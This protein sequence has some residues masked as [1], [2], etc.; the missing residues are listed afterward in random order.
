MA[1]TATKA[2]WAGAGGAIACIAL[3]YAGPYIGL[4]VPPIEDAA[5]AFT[6]LVAGVVG[7]AGA[8][9]SAWAGPANK[10]KAEPVDGSQS[11]V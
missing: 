7:Y 1:D 5:D 2:R 8:F 6:R 4:P 10:P 11:G 3:A 9:A